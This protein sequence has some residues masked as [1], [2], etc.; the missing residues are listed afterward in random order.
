VGFLSNLQ[1]LTKWSSIIQWSVLILI[2]FAALLQIVKFFINK[3]IEAI[4]TQQTASLQRTIEE[5]EEEVDYPNDI[6]KLLRAMAENPYW[7]TTP[8]EFNKF[9]NEVIHGKDATSSLFHEEVDY[10]S[11]LRNEGLIQQEAVTDSGIKNDGTPDLM[12]T[13]GFTDKAKKLIKKWD[14][15]K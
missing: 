3:K 5:L 12:R 10:L 15:I 1:S 13:Y 9:A 4:R 6:K 8:E 2:F 7:G 11:Y 14:K